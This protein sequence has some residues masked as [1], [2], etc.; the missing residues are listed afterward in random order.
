MK[1]QKSYRNPQ[2]IPLTSERNSI[3]KIDGKTKFNRD[4]DSVL[5]K[6]DSW[7][8]VV[9]KPGAVKALTMCKSTNV[10]LLGSY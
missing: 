4:S 10:S 2:Q 3:I 9:E 7:N 1:K 6:D 8:Y 5:S